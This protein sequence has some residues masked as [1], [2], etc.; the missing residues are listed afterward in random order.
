MALWRKCRHAVVVNALAF[1]VRVRMP[2]MPLFYWLATLVK[3][4]THIASP[5]FSAP[6]NW[7]TKGSRPTRTGPI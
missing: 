6:R 5:V 7:S 2:A 4:F 3:L 1:E